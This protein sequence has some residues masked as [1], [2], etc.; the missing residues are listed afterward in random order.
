MDGLKGLNFLQVT[1]NWNTPI[2]LLRNQLPKMGILRTRESGQSASVTCA[3]TTGNA[4]V[5]WL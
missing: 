2:L 3:D 5:G 4:T 1:P